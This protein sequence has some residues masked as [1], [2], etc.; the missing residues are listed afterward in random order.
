[1]CVRLR[2]K[3]NILTRKVLPVAQAA[4]LC[5]MSMLAR[6]QDGV[7]GINEANTKVRSYFDVGTNLMYAIGAIL[8][9]IGGIKVYQKWSAGHPDTGQTAAAW[10]GACVFLVVVA[11]VLKSFF[12]LV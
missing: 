8:G 4:V 6:A 10:F 3:D 7:A 11:T 5:V 1:M 2:V 9:L 12:G